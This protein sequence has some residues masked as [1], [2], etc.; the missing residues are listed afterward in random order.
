MN[1]PAA[2]PNF[3]TREAVTWMSE[4]LPKTYPKVHKMIAEGRLIVVD[5]G[6]QPC[7]V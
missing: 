3:T 1:T 6:A 4:K 7:R 5:Q 2:V